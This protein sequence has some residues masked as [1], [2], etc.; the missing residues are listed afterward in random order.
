M[1][2]LLLDDAELEA[3]LAVIKNSRAGKRRSRGKFLGQRGAADVGAG[4]GKPPL[5]PAGKKRGRPKGSAKVATAAGGAPAAGRGRPPKVAKADPRG[6]AA[7]AASAAAA[8]PPVDVHAC[9]DKCDRW[10]MLPAGTVIDSDKPWYCSMSPVPAMAAVGCDAPEVEGVIDTVSVDM[11]ALGP[12]SGPEQAAGGAAHPANASAADA[13]AVPR[14][15]RSAPTAR[16]RVSARAPP[17]PADDDSDDDEYDE[18]MGGDTS[19]E[20]D[21]DSDADFEAR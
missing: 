4:A 15:A 7:A 10:R 8:A 20:S 6:D 21:G 16:R 9:C 17:P 3:S 5:P 19:S 12:S 2:G 1:V 14:A 11:A 18:A 13:S